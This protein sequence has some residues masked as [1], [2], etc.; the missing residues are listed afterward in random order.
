[1]AV[2]RKNASNELDSKD[3][4]TIGAASTT[5]K[6]KADM[7][8]VLIIKISEGCAIVNLRTVANIKQ[9]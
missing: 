6:Y 4:K 9:V 7:F 8:D 5:T 3:W 1:M 2:G